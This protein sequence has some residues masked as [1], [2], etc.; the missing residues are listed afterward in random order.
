DCHKKFVK[1]SFVPGQ[2]ACVLCHGDPHK[3][4]FGAPHARVGEF[5]VL[6]AQNGPMHVTSPKFGCLD[7][8]N[9]RAWKPST[10]TVAKHA[11]FSYPLKGV[12]QAVECISCHLQGRFVGTPSDCKSCHLD[13]H[14]G[15][16]G[17]DCARCHDE[18][19]WQHHPNFDHA[20]ET[21]F[22]LKNAHAQLACES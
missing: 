10:V 17:S 8:H 18:S 16:V 11:E 4:Q 6:L 1:G 9:T 19:G 5:S 13:R 20:K 15:R 22:A 2:N 7:C 12:H 21:G 3:G 14:R